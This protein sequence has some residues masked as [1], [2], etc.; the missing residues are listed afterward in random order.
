MTAP[1]P[2]A[3]S[4]KQPAWL[5]MVLVAAL[6]SAGVAVFRQAREN[7]NPATPPKSLL[8]DDSQYRKT[9]PAL[10]KYRE[11]A[12]V[13]TGF[14]QPRGI[15]L[16]SDG[17]IFVAGDRAVR[18]FSKDGAQEKE[19]LLGGE[20]Y[21]LAA[22]DGGKLY[23][24]FMEHVEILG[25]GGTRTAQWEGLGKSARLT[26]LAV[27]GT[28]LWAADAGNRV[29]LHYDAKGEIVGRYGERDEAR[30]EP[31]LIVPSPHLD[32]AVASDGTVWFTNPGRHRLENWA[33]TGERIQTWG[34]PSQFGETSGT[35]RT[36]G[37]SPNFPRRPEIHG[38]CGCCNPT[39]FAFLSDGRFVTSEKGIPRVKVYKADGTFECV[40]AG[41]ESFKND[42]V[43]LDVA[44]DRD[45]RIY[46]LDP[47][48]KAVRVF[49]PKE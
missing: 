2:P 19:W 24:G 13:A 43:G 47:T 6:A 35:D 22:G 1:A 39:D 20:P 26:S 23:V 41:A 17:R 27:A 49:V 7:W 25:A 15:A 11:A 40:V 28:D 5:W 31:G 38:F 18:L 45:G 33:L 37:L 8:Y 32:V 10:V 14:R 48:V 36:S 16:S 30:K 29:V 12:P 46:V 3:A 21:C 44:T 9:D 34:Q 42:D 4:A